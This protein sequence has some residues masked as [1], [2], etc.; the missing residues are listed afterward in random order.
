MIDELDALRGIVAELIGV[1]WDGGAFDGGEL[2]DMLVKHGALY[3]VPAT[4]E[5]CAKEWAVDLGIEPGDTIYRA[6]KWDQLS[7]RDATLGEQDWINQLGAVVDAQAEDD[8]LWFLA[9]TAPEAY[10]Q[11]ELRKLHAMVEQAR[12]ATREGAQ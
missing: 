12:E 2:Q 4:P 1:A 5:D 3:E 8:G 11:Q 9:Q 6:T 10:L 7:A